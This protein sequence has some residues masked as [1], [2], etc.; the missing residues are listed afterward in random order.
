MKQKIIQV[1]ERNIKTKLAFV[2]VIITLI[3]I[4]FIFLSESLFSD[5]RKHQEQYS[6]SSKT[7]LETNDLIAH[8]YQIQECGN[9]FLMQR[10]LIY[11]NIYQA[12][13]DTF[14][15]KL[16]IIV[17]FLKQ[18]NKNYY[19][20]DISALLHK[21]KSILK[22]L[23]T[24][25]ANKKEVDYL[26]Q[27]IT[28]SIDEEMSREIPKSVKTNVTIL[29]DTVWQESKSFGQR[30]KDAFRSSK[31][32]EKEFASINTL[33]IN[34]I[35]NQDS[36][37]ITPLLDSLQDLMHRYQDQYITKIERI[38]LE[39]YGLLTAD[40]YITKEITTLL[41]QLHEDMLLQVI[42]LGEEYKENAQLALTRSIITGAIALL[43]IMIFIIFIFR[44]IKTIRITH[45]ALKL[46]KQKTEGMMEHRHQLLLAIS[47]DI[48]TPL[49]A[50]LEYLE[51]WENETL[52][53]TQLREL[54]TM[55]YSGKYILSLLNNLLEFTSLEQHK[56]KIS[57]ENIEIVPFFMEIIEMFKPLCNEKMNTLTYNIDVKENPQILIDALKLKQIVVNLISNAVK[58]TF[59]GT[60]NVHVEELCTSDVHLKVTI[61]DMGKGI[62]KE[63]LATLFEPFTRVE[64]N[65][66]GVEGSGLGLFVVKGLIDLMKGSIDIQTEENQGTVVTIIIPC[67]TVLENTHPL[68]TPKEPLQIWVIEDDAI[69]IQII[70]TMLQKLGHTAIKSTTKEAFEEYLLTEC[71]KSNLVFTD[72]EMG[73][74]NGYDVLQKIKSQF[75]VPVVCLSG[76]STTTKAELQQFGFDDFLEK[77]FTL[78]Q[79]E[80]ILTSVPKREFMTSSY[81]FSLQTLNEMFN[82]DKEVIIT[83]LNTFTT[84]L[85]NDIKRLEDAIDKINI[86]QIQQISH[87]LLPI[88]KQFNA[89]EVVPILEKIEL[90]KKQ[91]NIQF[92]D[93]KTDVRLLIENL[94]RLLSELLKIR[95]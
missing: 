75:N 38:E 5:F 89:L 17:Q 20:T 18:E 44:N 48:K 35:T 93:L 55:Q 86:F 85:P 31:K 79:L 2:Y 84:S 34:D 25:F 39:L 92:D 66:I 33:I 54:N 14:Q 71:A 16:E 28:A 87:R 95:V 94:K 73:D 32:R 56:S 57:Q 21:K 67:E 76:N 91:T 50:L 53:P 45:E 30:L 1:V 29:Q 26:Y 10:E 36:I 51:L 68:N 70:G 62:P 11:L 43:L 61:T 59:A 81:L 82:N 41:L 4:G 37:L 40:R 77:P 3:C 63:N 24:L 58:Y 42:S 7:L 49:N 46:E 65:S 12:N 9:Q 23:K 27:K 83:L 78:N 6:Q 64:K 90:L 22:E 60:I 15:K 19:I 52:S 8:F 74:L 47:H 13:I 69:Q 80:K 88:C 72:L